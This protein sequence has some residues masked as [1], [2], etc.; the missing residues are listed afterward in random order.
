MADNPF[1]PQQN[2]PFADALTQQPQSTQSPQQFSGY[3][4]KLGSAAGIVSKFLAGAAEGRMR[5]AQKIEQQN[6]QQFSS[7]AR[8]AQLVDDPKNPLGLTPEAR[9]QKSA[10]LMKT[11]AGM[12]QQQDSGKGRGDPKHPALGFIKN[13][14]ERITGGPLP[15]KWAPD[16]DALSVLNIDPKDTIQGQSQQV[17]SKIGQT[18]TEWKKANPNKPVT[19]DVLQSTGAMDLISQASRS[20][21]Q[22]PA[23]EALMKQA[24]DNDGRLQ[25]SGEEEDKLK[26][27]QQYGALPGQAEK[28]EKTV[29]PPGTKT[30]DGRDISGKPALRISQNGKVVRWDEAPATASDKP[31]FSTGTG[32]ILG[33]QAGSI[34]TDKLGQPISPKGEYTA[35]LD[36]QKN[37]VGLIPRAQE[38]SFRLSPDT[39]DLIRTPKYDAPPVPPGRAG[40]SA[41]PPPPPGQGGSSGTPLYM[42]P[43]PSDGLA[44]PGN[45]DLK[46]L[47][48]IDN[49][50]GS[51]STVYS[52]SFQDEKQGSP[53]Y[54]KEVLVRGILN[55]KKTD[56]VD[57]LRA[58]YYKDG[59]MLGAFNDPAS[60]DKY[61]QRLHQ[62]WADGKISGVQMGRGN[63]PPAVRNPS[64]GTPATPAG[65]VK[66]DAPKATTPAAVSKEAAKDP[67]LDIAAWDY[68]L[69]QKLPG[70]QGGLKWKKQIMARSGQILDQMGIPASGLPAMRADLKANSGALSKLTWQSTSLGQFEKTLQNNIDYARELN[71]QYDRT[72]VKFANRIISAA[73]GEASDPKV[74]KFVAQMD[75]IATEWA[76]IMAGSTSA[77]GVSVRSK[78][79]AQKIIDTHLSAGTTDELF[80]LIQRDIANRQKAVEDQRSELLNKIKGVT[81]PP[82]PPAANAAGSSQ[83]GTA[84]PAA[85]APPPP[86]AQRKSLDQ[87]FTQ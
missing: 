66:K 68:I 4:G 79:D 23:I 19:T 51:Y 3:E 17:E 63:S 9:A 32:V 46:T 27:Q 29:A 45:I 64:P 86:P 50:D 15:K 13:I 11:M 44:K 31:K 76:K 25:R 14:A 59:Q 5:Q 1:A 2:L 67:G 24:Q 62:D 48:V 43:G 80:D 71:S 10:A 58:K 72:D 30:A 60:A 12:V 82:A 78:A 18:L 84:A 8:I 74:T 49:K 28:S 39:G 65:Q 75:P 55:G 73:R 52:T 7:V 34:K 77:A 47:P 37:V 22:S 33:S 6:A 87:I 57:A 81:A 42:A 40:A 70:G 26:L 85:G 53:T 35:V 38:G 61:A 56:D 69:D 20:G 21:V 83:R 36:E 16:K 54:G 41:A